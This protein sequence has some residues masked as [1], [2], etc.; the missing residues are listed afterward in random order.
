MNQ[1]QNKNTQQQL[2]ATA[3]IV[4][5]RMSIFM[6]HDSETLA[7]LRKQYTEKVLECQRIDD[8]I[9]QIKDEE[10]KPAKAEAKALLQDIRDRGELVEMELHGFFNTE[11]RVCEYFDN[12]GVLR[13][14]R[15]LTREERNNLFSTPREHQHTDQ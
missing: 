3:D 8:R 15:M 9:T 7:K 5:E 10:L 14:T 2:R 13:H 1:N 4:G 6:E 11:K 12:D